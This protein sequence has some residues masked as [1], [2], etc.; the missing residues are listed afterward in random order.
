[1]A[2][3]GPCI[4]G[5][6]NGLTVTKAVVFDASGTPLAVARRRL[7]QLMPRPRHVERAWNGTQ[8]PGANTL[9][10]DMRGAAGMWR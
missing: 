8:S 2:H 9:A 1:M 6:D 5:I 4:L 3:S 7:P 10:G